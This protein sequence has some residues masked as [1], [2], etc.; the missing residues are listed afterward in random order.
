MDYYGKLK[1]NLKKAAKKKIIMYMILIVI[2]VMFIFTLSNNIINISIVKNVN[3]EIIDQF[4]T[5]YDSNIKFI[6]SDIIED[7]I[8]YQKSNDINIKYWRC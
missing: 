5:L 8:D 6:N 2:F 3:D 7:N 1:Q 4:S